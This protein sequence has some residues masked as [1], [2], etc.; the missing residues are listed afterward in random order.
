M[1]RKQSLEYMC[2]LADRLTQIVD[3]MKQRANK[4]AS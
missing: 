2:K 3:D 1:T 4:L